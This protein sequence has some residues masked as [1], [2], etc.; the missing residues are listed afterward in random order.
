MEQLVQLLEQV[1]GDVRNEVTDATYNQWI[2]GIAPVAMEEDSIILQV[3][4]KFAQS[5][6]TNRYRQMFEA[7]FRR[8]GRREYQVFFV[9]P[10]EIQAAPSPEKN[11]LAPNLNPK[12]T[13]DTFVVGASN[14]LAY[15]A[16]RAVSEN[17][18]HAYNP[19]FIYGGAGLGKTHLMQAIGHAIYAANPAVKVICV[20]SEKFT[21]EFITS[22]QNKRTTEFRDYYRSA[23]VLL[24]DD[25]HFIAGKESTEE[26]FFH[27]F[28]TLYNANKAIIMTSDQQPQKIPTLE[29][30]LSSRFSC[31]LLVDIQP[32]DLE[33]R[34]AILNK[35][36]LAENI[37]ISDEV[38]FYIADKIESNIRVLEGSLTRVMAYAQLNSKPVTRALVDDA[39]KDILADRAPR[40]I[41]AELIQQRVGEL[42]G[43][44]SEDFRSKKR[45]R[46]VSYARQV[47]MYLCRELTDLSTTRIGEAFGGRDHT[48]VMYAC[49]KIAEDM[50]SDPNIRATVSDLRKRISENSSTI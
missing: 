8:Y 30:R 35:K 25:I 38:V 43:L 11:L 36:A 45:N 28:N 32:P 18:G 44:K 29:E 24:I 40:K 1:K 5:M 47:A 15:A 12:F 19:L 16:C 9:L 49:E 7:A 34:V 13:F 14:Q 50:Q 3:Q 4:S 2:Q 17:P 42:Y 48:T 37:T 41:D 6:L 20:T 22:L 27:T 26:E 33:T 23:D 46:S 39:L 21:N 10:E 31:G